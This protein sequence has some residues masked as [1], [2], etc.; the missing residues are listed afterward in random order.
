[1][2]LEWLGQRVLLLDQLT[3]LWVAPLAVT[4]TRRVPCCRRVSRST[5]LPAR[6][7][8]CSDLASDLWA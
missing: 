3:L 8:S 6:M 1:M 5:H 4:Y 7:P 2:S